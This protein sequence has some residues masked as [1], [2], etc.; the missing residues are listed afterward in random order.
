M[1]AVSPFCRSEGHPAVVD[2]ARHLELL[3]P[4]QMSPHR[5]GRPV[6]Q[7]DGCADQR[8]GTPPVTP[9]SFNPSIGRVKAK[10]GQGKVA[11]DDK[12]LSRPVPPSCNHVSQ[13]GEPSSVV[14]SDPV[15][16]VGR[17]DQHVIAQRPQVGTTRRRCVAV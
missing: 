3:K 4:F 8:T 7:V 16:A 17:R 13:L 12:L 6:G 1:I 5:A 2:G 11:G 9:A 14:V 10:D 15:G